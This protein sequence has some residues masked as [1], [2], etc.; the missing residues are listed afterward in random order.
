[1]I[2][3]DTIQITPEIL[4]LIARLNEFKGAWRAMGT[5]APERLRGL[6]RVALIESIGSS[7]RI[8]G[9]KLT[10]R[11]VERLLS[12]AQIRTFAAGDE[13]EVAGYAELMERI[14]SFWQHIPFT[15]NHIKQLHRDLLAY[16][17]K[18]A[19]HR[20]HYKT[21]S[22]SAAAFEENGVQTGVVP[23][24]ATPFDTPRLMSELVSWV[25]EERTAGRLHPLL[26]IAL[27]IAVFLEIHPFQHGNGRLSRVL[28]TLLLLQSGY[29]YVQYGS[30]ENVIE[31][32]KEAYYLAL[33]QTLGTIRTDTPN[34]QPWL[35]FFLR[36]LAEQVTGLE[37]KVE[38]EN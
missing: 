10:D 20:G 34:W 1:M 7:I 26:I 21:T 16:S 38:R 9:S 30:L 32:N 5:L 6:R 25:Q 18:D 29:T 19:W 24:T 27:S 36:S 31:Q 11:E 28:T 15:V 3:S 23:Q 17:E 2:R 35:V 37:R 8:E 33:Q 12:N 4:A 13:Q 14:F 22:N